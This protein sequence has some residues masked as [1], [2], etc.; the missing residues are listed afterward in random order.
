IIFF[1]VIV[2]LFIFIFLLKG[3]NVFF[4]SLLPFQRFLYGSNDSV[5][6]LVQQIENAHIEVYKSENEILRKYLNFL[7]IS[8]DNFVMANVVGKQ[9]E[10]GSEWFLLDKG[11]KHG[12]KKGLAVVDENSMLIG[13]LID[14]KSSI[15]YLQPVFD[16][17]SLIAVDTLNNEREGI[18]SGIIQGEY[19]LAIKMKYV[20][21]DKQI[22]VGDTVIT[23]GLD[24]N[25]RRG[26]IIGSIAEVNKT[27][28]AI[29]QSA[30][31]R[32]LFN[33]NFRIVSI[34]IP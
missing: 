20:P 30:I 10:L 17:H 5:R 23:S 13:I 12:L 22:N 15:A 33:P 6:D 2:L 7:E 21:V 9:H 19:G 34:L 25:I 31:I 8:H 3:E 1:A 26:I 11:E 16:R 24:E 29:F 28:N 4:I 27:Q 32:P 18:I 14:V